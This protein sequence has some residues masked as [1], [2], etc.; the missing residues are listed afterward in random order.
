MKH[1]KD[2]DKYRE[3][4]YVLLDLEEIYKEN[5]KNQYSI[6]SDPIYDRGKISI[7]NPEFPYPY[8]IQLEDNFIFIVKENE[9]KR[10]LTPNEIEE[11]KIKFDSHRYNL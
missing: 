7:Y 6:S 11:L 1:L 8:H 9:I 10:K 2:F 4:D 3:G 5:R